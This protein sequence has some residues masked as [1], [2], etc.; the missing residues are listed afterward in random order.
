MIQPFGGQTPFSP[1][2]PCTIK[3]TVLTMAKQSP[4]THGPKLLSK[5]PV[6]SSIPILFSHNQ[7]T[8]VIQIPCRKYLRDCPN[9]APNPSPSPNLVLSPI[10]ALNLNL[11]SNPTPSPRPLERPLRY[12]SSG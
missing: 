4:F 7:S 6:Q 11:T 8:N 10:L 2:I 3:N 1:S 9:P 5:T 12:L